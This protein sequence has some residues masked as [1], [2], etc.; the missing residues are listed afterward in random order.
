MI[1]YATYSHCAQLLLLDISSDV[2]TLNDNILI[3]HIKELGIEGSSPSWL[4]S[5][6]NDRTSSIKVNDYISP[7]NDILCGVPQGSVLEHLLFSID[8]RPLYY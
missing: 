5:F 6:L 2:D 1:K 3:E 4:I 8:L 7:P